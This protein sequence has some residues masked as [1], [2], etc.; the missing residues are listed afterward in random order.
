M[1]PNKKLEPSQ[2][3]INQQ[4]YLY[5]FINLF[6]FFILFILKFTP[7]TFKK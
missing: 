2:K 6:I 3:D 7:K 1:N 4:M 5:L